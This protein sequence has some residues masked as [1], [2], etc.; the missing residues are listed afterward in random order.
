[1]A[2]VSGRK[3]GLEVCFSCSGFC[4]R[5]VFGLFRQ[6]NLSPSCALVAEFFR[7]EN[8]AQIATKLRSPMTASH[9]VAGRIERAQALF[10]R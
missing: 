1:M 3:Q 8:L 4:P 5:C 7:P 10:L 9:D 2:G 6:F